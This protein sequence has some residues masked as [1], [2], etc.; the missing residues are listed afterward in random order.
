MCTVGSSNGMTTTARSERL[1]PS[2]EPVDA[3]SPLDGRYAVQ[4]ADVATAFSEA[5]LIRARVRIEIEWLLCLAAHPALPAIPSLPAPAVESVRGIVTGF[6]ATDARRV[7]EIEARTR[8]DVKAVEYYLAERFVERGLASHIP[9]LHITLTS[10]D[11]NNVA[12]ALLL[13][14]GLASTWR[15]RAEALVTA[16][17]NLAVSTRALPMLALTHGQPASPTTLGKELAV[18]V[19]RWERQLRHLDR[20]EYLGKWNGA[21]G[22]FGAHL[23]TWPD[24]PWPAIARGFIESLGLTYA[25]ITT[26]IEPHDWI[27]ETAHTLIRFGQITIDFAR[28]QWAYIS[29]GILR[30]RV[31]AGEVG[32]STMPHKVNPI[33]FENAEANLGLAGA[34]LDHLAMKLPISRM[35]RDL[36]DSSALRNLGSG[37]GY[38]AV[39]LSSAV[40]GLG[41]VAPDEDALHAELD[42][43]W[44]VLAEPIQTV[45]RA[46]GVTDAY[47]HLL[48]LTRGAQIGQ[49]E[50]STAIDGLPIPAAE[51]DRLRI[52]TPWT[53][54]GMAPELVSEVSSVSSEIR[55]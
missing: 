21:T 14:D 53:Y 34:I 42:A 50:I 29:R 49:L 18:F 26:Q 46:H 43:H 20:Q 1:V 36:S 39:A 7:K 30:Q 28:D 17:R 45:L 2:Y 24:A 10:E 47:E 3:L 9:F 31:V 12:Y 32:S 16:T 40:R 38:S 48:S 13:R 51:R 35:Q 5:A 41:R 44:E 22:T 27:A 37:V 25:P 33:D 54:V 8:H 11:V 55:D 23:A 15:P 4:V 19:A 52:L 6:Q